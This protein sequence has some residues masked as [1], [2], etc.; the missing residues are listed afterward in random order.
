MK[1][2]ITLTARES[3]IDDGVWQYLIELLDKNVIIRHT[4]K[5]PTRELAVQGLKDYGFLVE[6][7]AP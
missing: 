2:T 5:G 6:E 4:S 7:D 3:K 1:A